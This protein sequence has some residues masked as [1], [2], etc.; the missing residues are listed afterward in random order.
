MLIYDISVFFPCV[1]TDD[2]QDIPFI[3]AGEFEGL[4]EAEMVHL[5]PEII[6]SL[7]IAPSRDPHELAD[8]RMRDFPDFRVLIRAWIDVSFIQ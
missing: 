3:D 5:F 6:L 4:Q 1:I 2:F 8:F 7:R